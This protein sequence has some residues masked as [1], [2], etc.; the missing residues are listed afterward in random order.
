MLACFRAFAGNMW[1]A[2]AFPNNAIIAIIQLAVDSLSTLSIK[3][4]SAFLGLLLQNPNVHG[5][6]AILPATYT[7]PPLG[8]S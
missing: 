1:N 3:P 6:S 8:I 2:S 5:Q 7:I 4:S